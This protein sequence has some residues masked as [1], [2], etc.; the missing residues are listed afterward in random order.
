M[1]GLEHRY[2]IRHLNA[3]MKEKGWNVKEF[4]DAL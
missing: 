2:C 3:N 4:K 1:P